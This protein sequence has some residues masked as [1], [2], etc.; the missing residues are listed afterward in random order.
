[1]TISRRPTVVKRHRRSA[2]WTLARSV[3][4]LVVC[5]LAASCADDGTPTETVSSPEEVADNGG[6]ELVVCAGTSLP[7]S[8]LQSL[9]PM[10]SRPEIEA[11][12]NVF[13]ETGEGDF[14]P[15]DGWQI[16]TISESEVYVIV[17]QTEASARRVAEERELEVFF[18]EGFGD[19][20]DDTI[21]FSAHNVTREDTT[22]GWRGSVSGEDCVLES[23]VPDGFNR[24][25]WE[26]DPGS[27]APGPGTE[28][29]DLLATERECT[30]GQQ[31]GD[32][33]QP[34]TVVETADAVLISMVATPP[35]GDAFTCQGN[36]STPV[37]V[38]L[39]SPLG[40]RELL[41][42]ATTAG[43][44]SDYVGETFGL[45]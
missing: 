13:L 22:W 23:V 43:R 8:A 45:P 16:V 24:V 4:A 11:A 39:S 40:D 28:R 19:G 29:L 41:D 36:P 12:V 30:G 18:D 20:I 44:L 14:W 17:L 1:M 10:S 27:A 37:T 25:D 9:E 33:L 42:G 31:M 21:L 35:E 6:E 5:L 7:L 15:Q 2:R 38:N 3:S 32:R 26:P 34:P